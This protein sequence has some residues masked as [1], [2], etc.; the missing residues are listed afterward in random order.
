MPCYA[1]TDQSKMPVEGDQMCVQSYKVSTM[2][3]FLLLHIG[4]LTEHFIQF[5]RSHD[6]NHSV[7]EEIPYIIQT[8]IFTT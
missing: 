3:K 8:L 6:N 4:S 5:V 1:A 7:T 2:T